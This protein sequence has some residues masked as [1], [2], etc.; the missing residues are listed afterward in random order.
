MS[1]GPPRM[2]EMKKKAMPKSSLRRASKESALMDC[3]VDLF[4]DDYA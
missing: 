1:R 4:D 3:S 2:M